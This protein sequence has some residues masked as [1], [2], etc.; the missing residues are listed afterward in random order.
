[1]SSRILPVMLLIAFP[2]LSHA[3]DEAVT[4]GTI[5]YGVLQPDEADAYGTIEYGILMPD[6]ATPEP[7]AVEYG[8]L[9]PDTSSTYD[10]PLAPGEQVIG[11]LSSPSI[12]QVPDAAAQ[13]MPGTLPPGTVAT[14]PALEIDRVTGLP[15]N[16]P[17]WSGDRA[18]PAG[19]GCFPQGVCA[20]LN[21]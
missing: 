18:R 1:M 3:Q 6:E 20:H 9:Q 16:M 5:E 14:A 15:R 4:Y 2:V 17:G 10:V 8:V 21:R 19:I 7:G 13:P 11:I 12:V